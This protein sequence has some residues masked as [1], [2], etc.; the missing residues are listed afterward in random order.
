M[1]QNSNMVEID[2]TR[3][4]STTHFWIA[5][6]VL[7]SMLAVSHYRLMLV[8][9]AVDELAIAI[10]VKTADRW[11]RAD[12]LKEWEFHL[13]RQHTG[14]QGEVPHTHTDNWRVSP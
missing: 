11:T 13:K 10:D 3:L 1:N 9:D 8:E 6:V 12:A 7:V 14:E 5:L 2:T 4:L